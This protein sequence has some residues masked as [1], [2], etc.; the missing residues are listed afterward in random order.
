M[1]IV[2]GSILAVIVLIIIFFQLPVSFVQR[3]YYKRVDKLIQK[4]KHISGTVTEADIVHLP[5]PIQRYIHYIGILGTQKRSYMKAYFRNVD[6]WQERGGPNLTIDYIQYNFLS[7]PD[8]M[9][10]IDS[11][12][13]G[14]P[15]EGC[16]SY[17]DGVGGMKGTI[18]K[19]VTIFNVTGKEMDQ[20]CLVTY[21]ADSILF[22]YALLEDFITYEEIDKN[23]VKAKISYY[24]I[25]TEGV[26]SIND[27][28]EITSFTTNDR[29]VTNDD[30][31]IT[32]VKWTVTADQYRLDSDGIK[33]PTIL[34]AIWNYD[35]G[36]FIY[37]DSSSSTIE[38]H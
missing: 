12:M 28:G 1:L 6:F 18:G 23:H 32:M 36:D 29:G 3:D 22:P 10:L 8:R 31:S 24:G 17:E 37:F 16:D 13:K 30:G 2:I 27:L 19:V 11:K 26:F 14:I 34:K 9:A 25:E 20:A 7:Q 21:L 4:D 5:E 38:Y 15:F 35:D 33:K